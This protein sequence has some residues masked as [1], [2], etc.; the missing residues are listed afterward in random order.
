MILYSL[1]V[2]YY[3]GVVVLLYIVFSDRN[4]IEVKSIFVEMCLL[5]NVLIM[6]YYIMLVIFVLNI[7]FIKS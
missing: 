2:R 6:M 4:K 1:F 5:V 3:S 7:E